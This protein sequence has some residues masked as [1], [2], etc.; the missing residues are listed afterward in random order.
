MS[1]ILQKTRVRTDIKENTLYITLHG[2]LLEKDVENIYSDIRFGVA[3]LQPGFN[4]VTDLTQCRIGSLAGIAIF[5]KIMAY[6]V[7]SEVGQTIRIVGKAKLIF[8]QMS[9]IT[10]TVEG[11]SPIYVATSEEADKLVKE[12]RLAQSPEISKEGTG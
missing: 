12:W 9:R 4:V 6:L 3:D 11:Y 8:K 1:T 7:T 5:K 10:E 2:T